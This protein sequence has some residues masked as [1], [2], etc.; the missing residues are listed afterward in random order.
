MDSLHDG[1]LKASSKDRS[2]STQSLPE[3]MHILKSA[4]NIE[5]RPTARP[6]A[7]S[8][9]HCTVVTAPGN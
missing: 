9:S 1:E 7:Q 4:E 5:V 6:R 3:A 2:K 8:V